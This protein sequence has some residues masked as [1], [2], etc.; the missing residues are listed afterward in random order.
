MSAPKT[1]VEVIER[2][3]H[4][5]HVWK[6]VS[7]KFQQ[8]AEDKRYSKDEREMVKVFREAVGAMTAELA[9][10]STGVGTIAMYRKDAVIEDIVRALA[11]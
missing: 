1:D 6:D 11:S 2:L 10:I 8:I 3:H 5:S 4:L 9:E 7:V